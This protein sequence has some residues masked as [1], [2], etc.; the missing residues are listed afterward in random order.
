MPIMETLPVGL[1][2]AQW[3][4]WSTTARLVRSALLVFAP[5]VIGTWAATAAS[6]EHDDRRQRTTWRCG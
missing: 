4:L 5:E 1:G 2:T 3:P 6:E